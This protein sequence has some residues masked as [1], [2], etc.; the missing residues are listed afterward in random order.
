M[1]LYMSLPPELVP[2]P[3]MPAMMGSLSVEDGIREL[4]RN[5]GCG[6]EMHQLVNAAIKATPSEFNLVASV[7][8]NTSH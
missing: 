8:S 7:K 5:Q 6:R 1:A 2:L 4:V 3:S